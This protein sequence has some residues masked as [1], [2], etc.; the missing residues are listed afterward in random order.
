MPTAHAAP[1]MKR[2]LIGA[3]DSILVWPDASASKMGQSLQP[4]YKTVHMAAAADP[5]FYGYL[6]LVDGIRVGDARE[7]S[8]AIKLLSNELIG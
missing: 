7:S 3:S 2:S 8:V 1:I 6:A 4:L 5:V